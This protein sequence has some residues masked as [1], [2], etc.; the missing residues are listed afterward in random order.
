MSAKNLV[1]SSRDIVRLAGTPLGDSRHV[2]AFFHS[3]D[4]EYGVLMPYIT[5][6]IQQGQRA[7]HIVDPQE[8]G[9]HCD[10]LAA[11]GIDVGAREQAGQLEVRIWQ[12]AYLREDRF[13]QDRMLALI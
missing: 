2:C 4:E 3:R 8:R 7:F 9:D 1:Q 11:A 5:E 13:D 6:G 10:R 12:E